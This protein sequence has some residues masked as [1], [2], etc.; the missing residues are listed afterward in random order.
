MT[1]R[2]LQ[3]VLIHIDKIYF[4]CKLPSQLNIKFVKN[5]WDGGEKCDGTFDYNKMVISIDNNLRY[6]PD[7]CHIVV[8]HESVHAALPDYKGDGLTTRVH[9]MLFQA[10]IVE[11]FNLGCYD[12]VL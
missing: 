3:L 2:D 1:D 7:L 5:L 11:L 12:G 10:K 6:H 9:G 8:A 4:D